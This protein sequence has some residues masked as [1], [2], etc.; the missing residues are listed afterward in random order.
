MTMLTLT[1]A[2]RVV[3]EA[4]AKTVFTDEPKELYEPINYTLS[5]G[6]KRLRPSLTLLSCNLFTDNYL[7]CFAACYRA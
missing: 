7:N 6:G 4:V 3:A 1:E 5:A 2:Q